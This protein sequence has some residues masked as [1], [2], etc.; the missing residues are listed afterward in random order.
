VH[1]KDHVQTQRCPSRPQA[2]GH[3]R[4]EVHDRVCRICPRGWKRFGC[5][6][7]QFSTLYTTWQSS[8]QNCLRNQADLVIINSREEMVRPPSGRDL[9]VGVKE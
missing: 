1:N 8:Q 9:C 6:C 3:P 7:Y 5:S 4:Q 2:S